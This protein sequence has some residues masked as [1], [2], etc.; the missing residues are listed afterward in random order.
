MLVQFLQPLDE[1]KRHRR[2]RDAVRLFRLHPRAGDRPHGR[3]KVELAPGR[4]AHFTATRTRE[5]RGKASR[6]A[7]CRRV[8]YREVALSRRRECRATASRADAPFSRFA[9]VEGDRQRQPGSP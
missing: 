2:E 1:R 9:S 3:V 6:R 8:R 4:A 5:D 7:Y